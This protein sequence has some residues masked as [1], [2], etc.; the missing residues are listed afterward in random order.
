MGRLA[1]SVDRHRGARMD[2]RAPVLAGPGAD[3]GEAEQRPHGEP[4]ET[5]TGREE[6]GVPLLAELRTEPG[7]ERAA[8]ERHRPL[9]RGDRSGRRRRGVGEALELDHVDPE[10]AARIDDDRLAVDHEHGPG[11]VVIADRPAEDGE[12]VPQVGERAP[13]WPAGPDHLGELGTGEPSR[14]FGGQP[15]EQRLRRG[16]LERGHRPTVEHDLEPAQEAHLQ[17]RHAA[18]RPP[19]SAPT[20][21]PLCDLLGSSRCRAPN[22]RV[23]RHAAPTR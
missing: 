14:R 11:T 7:E 1:P 8:T 4:V 23:E 18:L 21:S 12:R 13:G 9:P 22:V 5:R 16:R 17:L 2:E 6:P 19:R 15:G 20:T 10:V 3:L